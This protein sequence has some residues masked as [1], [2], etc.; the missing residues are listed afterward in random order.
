MTRP[1]KH[2]GALLILS[3]ALT[4]VLV[5]ELATGP[6]FVPRAPQE[7]FGTSEVSKI[8]I[9]VPAERPDLANF[10]SIVERPLFTPSRRPPSATGEA[11]TAEAPSKLE[12]Y[13][14]IGVIIS[15]GRRVALLQ[16]RDKGEILM[17]MEGQ[18][19]GGWDVNAIKP[20]EVVLKRGSDKDILKIRDTKISPSTANSVP[21]K[22][23]SVEE[24]QEKVTLPAEQ[25]P[26]T[27]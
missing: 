3:S 15:T 25:V 26:E 12:M 9:D 24:S 11:K 17:A 14:L 8:S 21:G 19:V 7:F 4:G 22:T 27:Q 16:P 1:P 13:D 6:F 23:L 2:I 10:S 18:N 20:T 5:T